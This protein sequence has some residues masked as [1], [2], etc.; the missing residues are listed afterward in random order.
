MFGIGFTLGGSGWPG[1]CPCFLLHR[2]SIL[3][4][5]CHL[6][7]SPVLRGQTEKLGWSEV[8]D[9][10][11]QNV[12]P[13]STP[14][15]NFARYCRD[16]IRGWSGGIADTKRDRLILWGGG[17]NGYYGNE[18]YAFDLNTL[19]LSRLNDPSPIAS[20]SGCPADLTDGTPNSRHTYN[21]LAYVE[22][23]DRMYAFSG[24]IANVDGC[25]TQDTWTLGLDSLK[26]KR[27]DPVSGDVPLAGHPVAAYDPNT[28]LV[29]V[30]DQWRHLYSYDY[31]TNAYRVYSNSTPR[32]LRM[33][34]AIDPKRKLFIM[35]GDQ[36]SSDGGGLRVYDI[37]PKSNFRE[38]DWTSRSKGCEPLM[39]AAFPGLAYDPVLDRIVGWPNFGNSIYLLDPDTISCTVETFP[40]GPPDSDHE[41]PS[42]P[43]PYSNGTFG[44]FRYFPRENTYVLLNDWDLNVFLLKL[45]AAGKA[46]E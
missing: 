12:C 4:I 6:L 27:M 43:A 2:F 34:A 36:G 42:K 18:L 40:G 31:D 25:Q 44:R 8:P 19:K 26:W 29:F 41:A 14:D 3:A 23:A 13:P 38:Q 17:H 28:K 37:G 45:T 9:T 46:K 15:Y 22:Q 33:T 21:E 30:H 20:G 16:V 39:T 32:A 24:G 11:L 1:V 5:C 35:F 7:L 10:K